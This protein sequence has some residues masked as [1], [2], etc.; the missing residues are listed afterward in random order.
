MEVLIHFWNNF[1]RKSKHFGNI[2]I[3]YKMV[4]KPLHTYKHTNYLVME[5]E[6]EG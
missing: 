6:L 5:V 2:T 1:L 4:I 3:K